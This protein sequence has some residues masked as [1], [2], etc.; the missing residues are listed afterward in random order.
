MNRIEKVENSLKSKGTIRNFGFILKQ[1][2]KGRLYIGGNKVNSKR[3]FEQFRLLVRLL[4]E[5]YE[6]KWDIDFK[7]T[8]LD[9][10]KLGL[11]VLGPIIHFPEVTITNRDNKSHNIKDLFVRISMATHNSNL[12]IAE[13]QGG[14]TTYTYAEVSSDYSHSHLPG[15]HISSGRPLPYFNRFCTGS[16]HINDFIAEI[17][18]GEVTETNLTRLLVQIIGLVSYESIE[19]T[20]HRN[21]RNIFIRTQSGRHYSHSIQ[22]NLE[23]YRRLIGYYKVYDGPIPLEFILEN[24]KYKLKDD[25]SFESFLQTI[26]FTES[27]KGYY[28][29][30]IDETGQAYAYGQ[31]PGYADLRLPVGQTFI[32]RNEVKTLV[33]TNPP[34]QIT[35][36][37]YKIHPKVKEDIKKEIEYDINKKSVRKSTI[38]RYSN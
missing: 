32:F 7:I 16:G 12:Y 31:P 10:S 29:A 30:L 5:V 13:I 9:E 35:N 27:E 18:A 22:R 25:T 8:Q 2:E 15:T 28:L 36:I 19:G 21:M 34:T 33:V 17:N 20:P 6:G 4:N 24:G 38:D 26:E 23:L 11:N 1:Y 37:E 3:K 14:R